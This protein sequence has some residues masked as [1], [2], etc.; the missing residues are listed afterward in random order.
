MPDSHNCA[1]TLLLEKMHEISQ[2]DWCAGWMAGLEYTLWLRGIEGQREGMFLIEL[3]NEARGWW[4]WDEKKAKTDDIQSPHC[5]RR[6]VLLHEWR[7]LFAVWYQKR[8]GAEPT[9]PTP[10]PALPVRFGPGETLVLRSMWPLDAKTRDRITDLIEHQLPRRSVILPPGLELIAI[11]TQDTSP[12]PGD[13]TPGPREAREDASP[14]GAKPED[15]PVEFV[16]GW[17]SLHG[18][19]DTKDGCLVCIK[20][21]RA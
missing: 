2:R 20:V 19:F 5:G 10:K 17:C 6:F 4:I 9:E 11:R 12:V 8:T 14:E 13:K 7:R 3:A 16:E 21:S 1:A 18:R 15:G